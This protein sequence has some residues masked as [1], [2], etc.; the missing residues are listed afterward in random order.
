M[1]RLYTIESH[2]TQPRVPA[3]PFNFGNGNFIVN[4]S[5]QMQAESR[6]IWFTQMDRNSDGDISRREFLGTAAQFRQFDTD[7]DQ[8]IDAEEAARA[9]P[10]AVETVTPSVPDDSDES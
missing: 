6:P 2:K 3:N 9:G 4:R 7:G 10:A 8:L 1:P 5:R